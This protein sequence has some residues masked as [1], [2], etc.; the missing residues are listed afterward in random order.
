[1]IRRLATLLAIAATATAVGGCGSGHTSAAALVDG[2]YSGTLPSGQPVNLSVSAGSVQVNG[3]DAYLVD[4]TTTA[5]FLV[6]LDSAHYYEWS[7]TMAEKG[8]SLH[9]DTWNAPR[10][11]ATPTAIPCVSPAPNT[12]GWCGGALHQAVDLLRICSAQCS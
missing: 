6:A 12:P 2:Q 10:G 11:T 4:P 5:Q 3:R 8:K 1:M 7:C 9:C